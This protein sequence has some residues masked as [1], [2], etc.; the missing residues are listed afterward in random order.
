[1]ALLPSLRR[2]SYALLAL[3]LASRIRRWLVRAWRRQVKPVLHI[4]NPGR[5]ARVEREFRALYDEGREKGSQVS[6]FVDGRC[7]FSAHGGRDEKSVFHDHELAI[8]F[9]ST[10]VIEALVVAML[11]DRGLVQYDAPLAKYVPGFYSPLVTVSDLMRHRAGC[12]VIEKPLTMQEAVEVLG[13]PEKSLEF[14][15]KRL[16]RDFAPSNP[17]RQEYHAVTRGIFVGL[18]LHAVTGKTLE[19]FVQDEIVRPVK[20]KYERDVE[21]HI[22]CPA[23]KQHRVATFEAGDSVLGTAADLAVHLSGLTELLLRPS[24]PEERE[25]FHR[26]WLLPEEVEFT[27]KLITSSRARRTLLLVRDAKFGVHHLANNGPFR[28]LPLSSSS[29]ISNAMSMCCI[30]SELALCGSGGSSNGSSMLL[31]Q[32]GFRRAVESDGEYMDESLRMCIRYAACG[33]GLNR[34]PDGWIGWAGAGGSI[35]LFHPE[36]R[37]GISYVPTRLLGRVHHPNGLR[38]LKALT[39][40][41]K[42]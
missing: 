13:S 8:V 24:D 31:S 25:V 5:L 19:Q 41:L 40:D 35:A 6:V 28:A 20:E 32:E 38:L 2:A 3:Y 27:Q 23:G 22:G 21:F 14:V 9:S 11:C 12:A 1:M 15:N 29:G 4:D 18:I 33:W 16:S 17:K 7:A 37:A 42:G 26:D 34:F 30:L 36:L 10:K 39:M